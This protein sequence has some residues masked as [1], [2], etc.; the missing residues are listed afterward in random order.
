MLGKGSQAKIVEGID[1]V[2][3]EQRLSMT[4]S[5]PEG[6]KLKVILCPIIMYLHVFLAKNLFWLLSRA[7]L[8]EPCEK[9]HDLAVK[10]FKIPFQERV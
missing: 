3:N 5:K 6:T 7:R 4:Y 1:G 9:D 8:L 2:V 10:A